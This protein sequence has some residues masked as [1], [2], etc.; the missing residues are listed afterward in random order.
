MFPSL[1]TSVWFASV[2]CLASVSFN[3]LALVDCKTLPLIIKGNS[4]AGVIFNGDEV[5]AISFPCRKPEQF[6]LLVFKVQA[7]NRRNIKR[8]WGLPGDD[9]VIDAGRYVSI[10]GQDVVFPDGRPLRLT[11]LQMLVLQ[12]LSGK[13]K[14]YF[15]L[16]VP[17]SVDSTQLGIIKDRFVVGSVPRKDPPVPALKR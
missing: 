6:D 8:I 16:G 7:D 11:R 17:G 5:T 2:L 14:G 1:I 15:V 12:P 9:L 4:L 10:N 13:L 3:N